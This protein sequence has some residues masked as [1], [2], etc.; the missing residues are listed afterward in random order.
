MTISGGCHCGAVRYVISGEVSRHSLCHCSD[1]RRCAG[2]V[3]VG[4][5]SVRR[6]DLAVQGDTTIY[7]SSDDVERRFCAGC[8]T[9][10]FYE[11][12]SL[13]PGLVDVQSAT[14]D[15][16]DAHVPTERIQLADAPEWLARAH[17]LPG[18][19]RFPE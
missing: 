8:G 12:E 19:R 15:D 17:L 11:S 9:G 3:P 4:W 16:P 7:R 14:F 13:F 5:A 2:A 18:H 1:C 10:L 6:E